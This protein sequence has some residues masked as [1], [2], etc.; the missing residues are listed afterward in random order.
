MF[1][2]PGF[3]TEPRTL[4]PWNS[5]WM[6]KTDK[7]IQLREFF[8][9]LFLACLKKTHIFFFHCQNPLNLRFCEAYILAILTLLWYLL[10]SDLSELSVARW[11]WFNSFNLERRAF[12]T[13]SSESSSTC[14]IGKGET[15]SSI[16][17]I[18][19]TNWS[20]PSRNSFPLTVSSGTKAIR[21]IT[22]F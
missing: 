15:G 3:T 22:G 13:V 8:F 6:T 21:F 2:C 4:R 7:E 19:W 11:W 18:S 12:L 1:V 14:W 10:K 17:C 20:N 9:I 16:S 5:I